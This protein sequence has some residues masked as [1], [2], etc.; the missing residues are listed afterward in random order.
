M[1]CVPR[2]LYLSSSEAY[3]QPLSACDALVCED[4]DS[5]VAYIRPASSSTK[6]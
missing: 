5:Q 3:V 2:N 4:D 1:S 6:R